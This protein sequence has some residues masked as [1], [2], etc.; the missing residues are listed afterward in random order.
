MLA[1]ATKANTPAPAQVF[2]NGARL[3]IKGFQDYVGLYLR[4]PAAPRVY[5]RVNERWE[6]CVCASEGQFQQVPRALH[7]ATAC[8]RGACVTLSVLM[9][10][11]RPGLQCMRGWSAGR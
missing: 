10:I 1:S 11:P 5:E 8:N 3:P 9:S 4:D 7:C 2:F 6:I